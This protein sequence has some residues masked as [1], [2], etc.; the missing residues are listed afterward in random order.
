M[1][2]SIQWKKSTSLDW[3]GNLD[4]VAA[5]LGWAVDEIDGDRRLFGSRDGGA[6][7]VAVQLAFAP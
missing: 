1:D 5:D 4:L 3:E 7:W 6:T 2:G